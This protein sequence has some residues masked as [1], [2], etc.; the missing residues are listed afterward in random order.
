MPKKTTEQKRKYWFAKRPKFN[1]RNDDDKNQKMVSYLIGKLGKNAL[2]E[3]IDNTPDPYYYD[4][5]YDALYGDDSERK[6]K[7]WNP[8]WKRD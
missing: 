5:E 2:Q 1:D 3:I 6:S 7:E 4:N 8:I